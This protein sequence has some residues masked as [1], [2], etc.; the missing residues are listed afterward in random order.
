VAPFI[1]EHTALAVVVVVPISITIAAVVVVAV[2]VVVVV[3]VV[4]VVVVVVVAAVHVANVSPAL[5][6]HFPE[7]HVPIFPEHIME[8]GRQNVY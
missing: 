7:Q 6:S 3:A 2:V 8:S 1:V 5:T 4:V